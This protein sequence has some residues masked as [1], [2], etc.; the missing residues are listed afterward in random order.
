MPGEGIETVKPGESLSFEEIWRLVKIFIELGI[1]KVRITG[2]EPLIRKGVVGLINAIA[3]M[4]GIEEI[5]VTTNGI[6]LSRYAEKL[7]SAGVSRLNISLDTLKEDKFKKITRSPLF[8]HVMAGIEK[9]KETRFDRLKLNT[10]IMKGINDD[11]I[12]DF[13]KFAKSKNLI[14]R[15]IEFMKVTPL[16]D[17]D[18]FVPIEAIK[19]ICKK[20]YRLE[21]TENP[22]PSPAEHYRVDG[23]PILGFIK[24]DEN[25]CDRCS[26][27]RL[28]S[29]GDLK[30]CL[31]ENKG[32]SLKG[33]LRDGVSDREMLKIIRQRIG[34]K[35]QV[36]YNSWE[37]T[38]TYM[39]S[40]GG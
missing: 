29:V 21:R 28:T 31:Y 24:T 25:N 23:V 19:R 22:G 2:G 27:L 9:A 17:E 1:R 33:L 18:L 8:Y 16:W 7:K 36:N 13:V 6:L 32:F 20:K 30:I 37:P 40:L 5:S 34:V 4:C 38:K 39:C 11:E 26:R 15:F 10:V 3:N 14:L 12:I 35:E